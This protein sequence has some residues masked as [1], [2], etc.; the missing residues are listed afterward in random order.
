MYFTIN[1]IG[2]QLFHECLLFSY[3]IRWLQFQK[4]DD[5]CYLWENLASLETNGTG[6]YMVRVCVLGI[7]RCV[8]VDDR[9]PCSKIG[10]CL[11]PFIRTTKKGR[12]R[13]EKI[14]LW[15]LILSKALL[16][17]RQQS[18]YTLVG[19][20]TLRTKSPIAGTVAR[21]DDE[22]FVVD[23]RD[24]NCTKLQSLWE[25]HSQPF[26]QRTV[27]LRGD[28]EVVIQV[29]KVPTTASSASS[30]DFT[31]S[32]FDWKNNVYHPIVESRGHDSVLL[33]LKPNIPYVVQVSQRVLF[34]SLVTFFF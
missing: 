24:Q 7:W 25:D 10:E 29:H 34:D 33:T 12:K 3:L 28:N 31:V 20:H 6:K 15:P 17:L 27:L 1:W 21:L 4:V 30:L 18:F 23:L 2:R 13:K 22:T 26:L 19:W 16:K 11:L 32:Q 9:L 8:A 5:G 14:Q